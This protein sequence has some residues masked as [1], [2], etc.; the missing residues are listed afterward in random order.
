MTNTKQQ[1]TIQALKSINF[2]TV[3]DGDT[4]TLYRTMEVDKRPTLGEMSYTL[5]F[6]I[7]V[8]MMNGKQYIYCKAAMAQLTYSK[9]NPKI[10]IY[11]LGLLAVVK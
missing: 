11:N 10:H 1:L 9:V 3:Q 4:V 2:A 8:E 7:Q 6:P 5:T